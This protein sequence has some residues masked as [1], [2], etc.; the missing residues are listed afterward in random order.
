VLIYERELPADGAGAAVLV[1]VTAGPGEFSL[2]RA[3]KNETSERWSAAPAASLLQNV[4]AAPRLVFTE[5][6]ASGGDSKT[7]PS[8]LTLSTAGL[9]GAIDGMMK[10]CTGARVPEAVTG[11]G[12]T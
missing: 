9:P 4:L 11:S 5:E 8:E 2:H 12:R 3:V 1:R 7:R 10:S 6:L